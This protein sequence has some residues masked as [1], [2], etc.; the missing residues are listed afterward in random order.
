MTL[1]LTSVGSTVRYAQWSPTALFR[2]SALT[3]NGHKIHYNEDWTSTVEGHPG[4][5]VHGPLNLI[6]M[7]DYWRDVYGRGYPREIRYRAMAPIYAGE[8]YLL[9][10]EDG[11]HDANRSRWKIVADKGGITC[12]QGEI[13]GSK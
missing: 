6:N 8:K 11:A 12:V 5:V 1:G 7:L 10:T 9:R 4:L 3:F 13:I 2:F